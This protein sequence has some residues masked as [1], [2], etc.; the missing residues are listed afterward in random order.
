MSKAKQ[1]EN[2]TGKLEVTAELG[3]AFQAQAAAAESLA[4][5]CKGAAEALAATS[6]QIN[7]QLVALLEKEWNDGEFNDCDSPD[8]ARGKVKRY[9]A[10][11]VM[12]CEHA[13]Q[14]AKNKELVAS[15]RATAMQQMADLTGRH[16]D[17]AAARLRQLTAP[18]EPAAA[19]GKLDLDGKGNPRRGLGERPVTI[20]EAIADMVAEDLTA[21]SAAGTPIAGKKKSGKKK[22]AKK[23]SGKKKVARKKE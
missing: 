14:I 22:S 18:D 5:A 2:F 3:E 7:S 13:A 15:G 21:D 20:D 1:I 16:N 6:S 17:T 8:A 10:R 9:I 12:F 23:K 19:D 4:S 11:A